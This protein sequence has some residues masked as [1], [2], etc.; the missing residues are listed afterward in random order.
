MHYLHGVP[1]ERICENLGDGSGSLVGI[2]QRCAR[3]FE[4]VP[5]KLFEEYLQAPVR[6]T[7]ETS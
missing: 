3:L 1:M 5:H 2:F 4:D 6:H 7:D